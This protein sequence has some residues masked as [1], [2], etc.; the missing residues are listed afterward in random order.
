MREPRYPLPRVVIVSTTGVA[1]PALREDAASLLFS[2]ALSTPG[3]VFVPRKA[4]RA[5]DP[6]GDEDG[7]AHAAGAPGR[8]EALAQRRPRR[9]VYNQFAG[10]SARQESTMILPQVHLRKPC[11][12]FSFL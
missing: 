11:Y 12:D 10:L 8:C 5:A 6:A 9:V 4:R 3:F 1:S 2:L 7:H